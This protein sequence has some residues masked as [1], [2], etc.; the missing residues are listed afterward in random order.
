MNIQEKRNQILE[1]VR[2]IQFGADKPDEHDP[3]FEQLE[4]E[5]ARLYPT[6]E[7][8]L[9]SLKKDELTYTSPAQGF[10]YNTGFSQYVS[11]DDTPKWLYANAGKYTDHHVVFWKLAVD[12]VGNHLLTTQYGGDQ[13]YFNWRN[14]TGA[15]KFYDSYD[16]IKLIWDGSQ[17]DI[18][19][20]YATDYDQY[21]GTWSSSDSEL[22][23]RGDSKCRN[24][25]LMMFNEA[26]MTDDDRVI[27]SAF[28]RHAHE[29]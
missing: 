22:Y 7:K 29:L 6:L 25:K 17:S 8:T 13:Y 21:V 10:L 28:R 27:Y 24:F 12:G 1:E 3:Q 5:L 23:V 20:I 9:V 16:S 26:L 19:Q 2:R 14:V 11:V 18:F 4:L 15:C